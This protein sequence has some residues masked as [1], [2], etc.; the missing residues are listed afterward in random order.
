MLLDLLPKLLTKGEDL[1]CNSW[2]EPD[3]LL[4]RSRC[5]W[6]RRDWCCFARRW[7]AAI[8]IDFDPVQAPGLITCYKKA[9]WDSS[10]R[11]IYSQ[12]VR[13]SKEW[14]RALL[15]LQ[16]ILDPEFLQIVKTLRHMETRN[17][18]GATVETV[19]RVNPERK[20]WMWWWQFRKKTVGWT[21]PQRAWA[22]C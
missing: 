6:G 17:R 8:L 16:S 4:V 21:Q 18:D 1:P 10:S 13:G 20:L 14:S 11:D 9:K 22:L 3:T 7:D 2:A 19:V 15:L 12:T 5:T